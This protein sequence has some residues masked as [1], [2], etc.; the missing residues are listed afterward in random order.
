MFSYLGSALI[1]LLHLFNTYTFAIDNG[2]GGIIWKTVLHRLMEEGF[3]G[4]RGGSLRY[5]KDYL[6]VLSKLSLLSG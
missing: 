5:E 4:G 3:M 6:P 1:Y 2:N